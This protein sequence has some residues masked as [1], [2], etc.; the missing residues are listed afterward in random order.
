[1]KKETVEYYCDICGKQ[2]NENE[3]VKFLLPV[4]DHVADAYSGGSQK[5]N[6]KKETKEI[7]FSCQLSI[8][9]CIETL[10]KK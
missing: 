3:L 6:V 1:M 5:P 2:R 7:C 4:R 9:R 10:E 8:T